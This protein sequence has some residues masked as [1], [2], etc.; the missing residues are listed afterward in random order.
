MR[1][2]RI[3]ILFIFLIN[4]LLY[5]QDIVPVIHSVPGNVQ[6]TYTSTDTIQEIHISAKELNKI[7]DLRAQFR[8]SNSSYSRPIRPSS[9]LVRYLKKDELKMSPEALYWINYTRDP[10]TVISDYATFRDT[11]IVNSLFMP[12]VFKGD[13]LPD[14]LTFYDKDVFKTKTPY[15]SLYSFATPFTE[16]NERKNVENLAH[17]YI[18]QKYPASFRYSLRDFPDEIFKP[19]EIKKD[20]QDNL[21]ILVENEVDF[22][23]ISAPVKFI[24]DRQYWRSNFESAIQFSQNYVSP[25]W[26]KGGSSNLNLFTTN[27]VKYNYQKDKIQFTNEAEL[28]ISVYTAPKDT[29]R[30]YKIGDDLLRFHSNIGYKAFNNWYYTFDAEFK[31]QLFNNYKENLNEK[32]A[33]IL[34]PFSVIWGLGM[35]YDLNKKFKDKYKNLKLGVNL[36][37]LSYTY[38]YS[39]DK[40]IDLGR[41]GFKK[42]ENSEEYEN[43]LSQFGSSIRADLTFNF[44]RNVSWQSRVYYFT[45]YDRVVGEFEN[46]LTLAISRFFSTRI[47][48]HIRFDDG[49]TK[50]EDFD[51][52]FQINELL[53][54]GFNYK[55]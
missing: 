7:P 10:S 52:Y 36:A 6:N 48:A 40:N 38:M 34:A 50:T 42:K 32:Q 18:E 20:I 5:A 37:P 47:Y 54:F 2:F 27:S 46:T 13:I 49:A 22:S 41:H 19:A 16:F 30:D 31:T 15:D 28:K 4:G 24:P 1:M 25:N 23:D 53:S 12:L 55:W 44:N 43:S 45:S 11:V 17:Q 35:K 33:A 29:L 14:D 39:I 9:K 51:S 8:K 21:P 3:I 26:H